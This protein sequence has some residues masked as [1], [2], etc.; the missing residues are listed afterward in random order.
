MTYID[1]KRGKPDIR[2]LIAVAQGRDLTAR[3]RIIAAYLAA[4]IRYGRRLNRGIPL[5]D[6]NQEVWL[7]A[8][9]AISSFDLR[10]ANGF[11][12][13]FRWKVRERVSAAAAHHA[14]HNGPEVNEGQVAGDPPTGTQ[15]FVRLIAP[16]SDIERKVV[17]AYYLEGRTHAEIGAAFGHSDEWSRR[18]VLA[19]CAKLTT[20]LLRPLTICDQEARAF[21]RQYLQY[22]RHGTG[23]LCRR[24]EQEREPPPETLV[25]SRAGS[26]DEPKYPCWS[27]PPEEVA[28]EIAKHPEWGIDQPVVQFVTELPLAA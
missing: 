16:L 4:G 9:K 2:A 23:A 20:P 28:A 25:A 26:A 6:L 18:Q 24:W 10:R 3:D 14:R 27:L 15:V 19:A 8:E 5:D 1:A 17:V 7:A 22:R 11:V 21:V 13:H 12:A